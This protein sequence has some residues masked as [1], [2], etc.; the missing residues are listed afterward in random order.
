MPELKG[1]WKKRSLG[2]VLR[3]QPGLRLA[4]G[5]L[6]TKLKRNLHL[7]EYSNQRDQPSG[8]RKREHASHKQ[9]KEAKDLDTSE[10]NPKLLLLDLL[11][12]IQDFSF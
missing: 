10:E 2:S 12:D 5:A 11:S 3:S 1:R 6:S 7:I 8:G 4:S 9:L